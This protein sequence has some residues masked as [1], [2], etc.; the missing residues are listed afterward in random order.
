[1]VH[2]SVDVRTVLQGPSVIINCIGN[3]IIVA[4]A[5]YM[6]YKQIGIAFMGPLILAILGTLVPILLGPYVAKAQHAALKAT[7]MRLQAMKQVTADVRNVRMGG[8]QGLTE[9]QV[10]DFRKLEVER[11]AKMRRILVVV[12][13]IGTCPFQIYPEVGESLT[14][15]LQLS[16]WKAFVC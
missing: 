1:M 3:N 16:A 7:E 10:T 13:V 11:E 6:L 15:H 9:A 4:V 8:L 2:A 14:D 12:V 5:S